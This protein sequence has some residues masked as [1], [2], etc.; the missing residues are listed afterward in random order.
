MGDRDN[1]FE[2]PMLRKRE[3]KANEKVEI[4]N[5]TG[6][7]IGFLPGM[8]GLDFD[9]FNWFS[10]IASFFYY[11]LISS[12]S[13]LNISLVNLRKFF[14]IFLFLFLIPMFLVPRFKLSL[15]FFSFDAKSR[16]QIPDLRMNE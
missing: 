7:N 13:S 12:F 9:I 16:P 5:E 4:F 1:N 14:E 8:L 6:F 11:P 10:F 15:L 3:A 2:D